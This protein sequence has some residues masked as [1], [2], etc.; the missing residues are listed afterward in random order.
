MQK[1]NATDSVR[2][3]TNITSRPIFII[4]LYYSSVYDNVYTIAPGGGG[5]LV[6]N[7]PRCVCPK[8]KEMGSFSGSR[9]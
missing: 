9:E 4:Y 5:D 7:M 2:I 6:S 3:F 8:A 1:C